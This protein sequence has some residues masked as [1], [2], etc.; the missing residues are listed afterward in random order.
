M[1]H[2]PKCLSPSPALP[3]WPPVLE[4]LQLSTKPNACFAKCKNGCF[5][6]QLSPAVPKV[7]TPDPQPLLE[8]SLFLAGSGN[9]EAFSNLF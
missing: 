5:P 6:W 1:S 3:S 8:I 9:E 7:G 4:F 2:L